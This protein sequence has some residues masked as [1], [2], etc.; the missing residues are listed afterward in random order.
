MKVS[1]N[2]EGRGI[3]FLTLNLRISLISSSLQ[4]QGF[5]VL[6]F[7]RSLTG[8]LSSGPWFIAASMPRLMANNC[9]GCKPARLAAL[10]GLRSSL[11]SGC[12]LMLLWGSRDKTTFTLCD[13]EPKG[14]PL[15]LVHEWS[16]DRQRA[17]LFSAATSV[18]PWWGSL[19]SHGMRSAWD[20]VPR[21]P[22]IQ[23]LFAP[24]SPPGVAFPFLSTQR[25]NKMS[26]LSAKLQLHRFDGDKKLKPRISLTQPHPTYS[27]K[28]KGKYWSFDV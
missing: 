26:V 21:W 12:T 18:Y 11:R 15:V 19:W 25:Y 17:N 2:I 14:E 20:P 8:Q 13:D 16:T 24:W 22:Y 28:G 5:T 4:Y 7:F 3:H 1:S 6:I 27:L 23:T 10:S 9:L